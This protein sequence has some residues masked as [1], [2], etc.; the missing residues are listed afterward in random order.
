M[1]SVP[2]VEVSVLDWQEGERSLRALREAVFM[3]EQGVSAE[4]EW[5]GLDPACR[6][7]LARLD[8]GAAVG[9]GRLTP[10]GKIGRVA[11]LPPWRKQGIGR[12]I[13]AALLDEAVARG[14][15][16]VTLDAQLSAVAFYLPL[17]FAVRGEVFMDAGMPHLH[18]VLE[19]TCRPDTPRR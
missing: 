15:G 9:C 19:P 8:N 16:R 7:V 17:G 13:M 11:V 12:A 6:H 14:H 2:G 5:D 18:M 3:R 4:L 10:A 1:P